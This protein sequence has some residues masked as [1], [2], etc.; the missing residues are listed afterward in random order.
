[1]IA[2]HFL[3]HGLD[4]V[5]IAIPAGQEAKAREFYSEVLGLIE[6]PVPTS[7]ANRGA[8]WFERESLRLHLGIDADFHPAKKAHPALLVKGLDRLTEHLQRAGIAIVAAPP[9]QGRKRFHIFDPFGNRIELL[10]PL[11]S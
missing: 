9:L 11:S 4:H 10:E 3:V 1:M 5:Q 6:V 2:S 7:L 8:I